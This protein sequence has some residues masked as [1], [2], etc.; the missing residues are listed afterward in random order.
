MVILVALGAAGLDHQTISL[1]NKL[2]LSFFLR[3]CHT[4]RRFKPSAFEADFDSCGRAGGLV[5]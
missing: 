1:I 5:F 2:T 3:K 4:P